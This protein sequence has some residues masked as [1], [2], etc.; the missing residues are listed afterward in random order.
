MFL[1]Y[2]KLKNKKVLIR[3]DY[4]VPI[5][6]NVIQS[7]KRIDASLKTLNY[8]LN[9]NPKQLI[10]VS[11]LG[12]PKDNDRSL[13]LEPVRSYL[14][15]LLNKNIKLCNLNNI[16]NDKI[17]MI[18]NIRFHK[19]ETNDINTTQTFR[20]KLTSLCDVYVND[21]FGCCHRAHSSIIGVQAE[22]KYLGFL[23]QNELDYLSTSLCTK[24]VKTLV[25]G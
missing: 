11:H 9:Q 21:A 7:T 13:S 3:T 23:V 10:I 16:S 8:I 17:I 25:L 15:D 6:N 2:S 18:E 19:E 1:Q 20:N 12:R 5:I 22:E 4:N 14:Q 24:G